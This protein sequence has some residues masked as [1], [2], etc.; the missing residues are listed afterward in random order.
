[1]SLEPAV[2]QALR[3]IC[4]STTITDAVA[5]LN[6]QSMEMRNTAVYSYFSHTNVHKWPIAPRAKRCY[7]TILMR[8]LVCPDCSVDSLE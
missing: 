4:N 2:E 6:R 3:A 5:L 1:M 8:V 7:L